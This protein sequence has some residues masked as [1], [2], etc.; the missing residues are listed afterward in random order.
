MSGMRLSLMLLCAAPTVALAAPQGL[1]KVMAYAGSWKTEVQHFDTP[2]SKAGSESLTLK[3]DCWRSGG[4][5]ACDQSVDGDSKALLVFMYDAKG[6]VYASY[7]IAPGA[8]DV[9]P[10]KLI[11]EGAVWTFPWDNTEAGKTT[12][13]REVN[14]WSSADSIEFRQEYSSDGVHW[15]LMAK[16]HETRVQ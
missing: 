6:D 9:H 1:D 14:T 15:M 13:F 7:P 3:N 12:H 10:G 4:F 8:S 5:L 2:F 11:I 16:G